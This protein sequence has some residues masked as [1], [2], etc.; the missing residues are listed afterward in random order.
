[1]TALPFQV[2]A[3]FVKTETA[4]ND[5]TIDG[6]GPADVIRASDKEAKYNTMAA[7]SLASAGG[8][9]FSNDV[10]VG[11][12]V[13]VSGK[14]E[15]LPMRVS[16]DGASKPHG[17]AILEMGGL[18]AEFQN[19]GAPVGIYRGVDV[20]SGNVGPYPL[21]ITI[22]AGYQI[23][24]GSAIVEVENGGETF[25]DGGAGTLTGDD[26]GTGTVNYTTGAIEVELGNAP[27]RA[28]RLLVSYVLMKNT[29]E[30]IPNLAGD[31]T[32]TVFGFTL[33]FAPVIPG[34]IGF[35]I[36]DGVET[37]TDGGAGTLTGSAGGTGAINY[38]TGAVNIG[39]NS[40][41]AEGQKITCT[42]RH[43][44]AGPYRYQFSPS[45]WNHKSAAVVA[46]AR[47]SGGNALELK[48]SGARAT[49]ELEASTQNLATINFSLRTIES[50][51]GEA[52]SI[53]RPA[54]FPAKVPIVHSNAGVA[55]VARFSQ[56]EAGAEDVTF[57]GT[58]QNVKVAF[59]FRMEAQEGANIQGGYSQI[60]LAPDPK[61][62]QE[63]TLEIVG[64]SFASWNP[65][66]L[67]RK[68]APIE[69]LISWQDVGDSAN[70]IRLAFVGAPRSEFLEWSFDRQ[71]ALSLSM[72]EKVIS[73]YPVG[74]R[75]G[76]D[77]SAEPYHGFDPVGPQIVL[78][79]YTDPTQ[80]PLWNAQIL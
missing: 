78:E 75:V 27:A 42:W 23:K 2:S 43:W 53:I 5:N 36:S 73:G 50:V 33:P 30:T 58:L 12:K 69:N 28:A 45:A 52:E 72:K 55:M 26:G 70:K 51:A 62:P 39:F 25:T 77:L 34:Y 8:F 4:Y 32:S 48:G 56:R 37:F 59:G 1:M 67:G 47:D 71:G 10:F 13:E 9:A 22:P 7:E 3:L 60:L 40:A 24:S 21:Q 38:T 29:T 76:G 20:E 65:A 14:L 57:D 41:P 68:S 61:A 16:H 31:G 49:L 74:F 15:L 80:N 63:V 6:I 46:Q 44:K 18:Q 66:N 54:A 11:E 35:Q 19:E 79:W 17:A 64:S